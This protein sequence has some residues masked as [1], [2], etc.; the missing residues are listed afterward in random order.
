V[1][2]LMAVVLVSL[3]LM[4]VLAGPA[5]AWGGRGGWHGGGHGGWRGG[6][7]WGGFALGLGIGALATAP[8]WYP[9]AYAYPAYAYPAYGY[10][11]YGYPAYGYPG[12]SYPAYSYQ[13]YPAPPAYPPPA[14]PPADPGAMTQPSQS[15]GVTYGT[16]P[17]NPPSVQGSAPAPTGGQNCYTVTVEGHNETRTLQSGQS[18]TAWVPTYTQQ[19]CQ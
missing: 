14:A 12:Y 7:C 8:F 4:P 18:V 16:P 6:C 2:K 9:P 17:S 10:P 3:L 1:K 13:A 5:Q 15:T 11:A 19:V